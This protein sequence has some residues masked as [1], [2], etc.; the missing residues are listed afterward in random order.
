MN[1]LLW[2]LSRIIPRPSAMNFESIPSGQL[3]D[4]HFLTRS[5]TCTSIEFS[6]VALFIFWSAFPQSAVASLTSIGVSIGKPLIR[7]NGI[8]HACARLNRFISPVTMITG[9]GNRS[10][11]SLVSNKYVESEDLNASLICLIWFNSASRSSCL[12]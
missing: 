4:S 3:C 2:V 7:R 1:G 6:F 12:G 9:V 8:P 10:A 11:H 5:V